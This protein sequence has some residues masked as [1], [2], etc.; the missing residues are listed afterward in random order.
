ML[1]AT[2]G[3]FV[4]YYATSISGEPPRV[5]VIKVHRDDT[6]WGNVVPILE[7]FVAD[8]SHYQKVGL[9]MHPAIKCIDAWEK[10]LLSSYHNV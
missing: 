7:R 5:V 1:N 10:Y 8:I 2:H 9:N 3:Y 6:W 4:E